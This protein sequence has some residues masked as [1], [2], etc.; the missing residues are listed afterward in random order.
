MSA[1]TDMELMLF[2]DGELEEP[3][4]AE[5]AAWLEQSDVGRAKVAGVALGGALLREGALAR[6][7]S[8]DITDAVMAATKRENGKAETPDATGA[9]V[10]PIKSKTPATSAPAEGTGKDGG[11]LLLPLTAL[12]AAAAAALFLWGRTEPKQVEV[13]KTEPT[14]TATSVQP[15][16]PT[17]APAP[18]DLEPFAKADIEDLGVQVASVNFGSRNG[19]VFIVGDESQGPTTAVVWVT[20]E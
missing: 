7:A 5:V 12:A 3:R 16:P 10:I 15:L 4:R 11:R 19:S 17:P 9:K 2:H 14:E 8:F 20:E 1:P 13:A 6:A 18:T